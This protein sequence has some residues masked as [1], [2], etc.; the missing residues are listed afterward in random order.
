M[1]RNQCWTDLLAYGVVAI[2]VG[3][4]ISIY[5]FSPSARTVKIQSPAVDFSFKGNELPEK[6][7]ARFQFVNRSFR[8]IEVTSGSAL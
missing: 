4:G 1:M 3:A 6:V 5:F 2:A 7:T 8:D